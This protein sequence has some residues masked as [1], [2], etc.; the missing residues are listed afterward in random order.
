MTRKTAMKLNM[1]MSYM[2]M[3]NGSAKSIADGSQEHYVTVVD[4]ILDTE[5]DDI[6]FGTYT[7]E[8]KGSATQVLVALVENEQRDPIMAFGKDWNFGVSGTGVPSL[9]FSAFTDNRGNYPCVLI[10]TV[11]PYRLASWVDP[12]HATGIKMDHDYEEM[13]ITGPSKNRE[14]IEV[15]R[16]FAQLLKEQVISGKL[17]APSYDEVTVFSE[18]YYKKEQKGPL[19]GKLTALASSTAYKDAVEDYFLE[20]LD[21]NYLLKAIEKLSKASG[22]VANKFAT[23]ADLME[24]VQ[25][26]LNDVLIHHIENRRWVDAFWDGARTITHNGEKIEV[27]RKPKGETKIQPTLHVVLDMALSPFGIQVI[28]ESGEGIG[29]LDFRCLFTTKESKPLSIGI[30]FKLAH[31]QEIRKGV[32]SQLPAYLRAIKSKSGIYAVMWFKDSGGKI[33]NS[34]KAHE[35][36]EFCSWLATEAE[37]ASKLSGNTIA[38]VVIDASIKV[39]AS[40]LEIV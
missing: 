17:R 1:D 40:N 18:V 27:P 28:R 10:R 9:P 31:H 4:F 29:S 20:G 33:F 16:V 14:K 38:V 39:S 7:L 15:L 13:Q 12:E 11:F 37:D 2:S 21:R 25:C 8:Y 30:E 5:I 26:V 22:T 19:L 23:E 35:K 24:V 36:E 3:I 6:K 34:P 32:R